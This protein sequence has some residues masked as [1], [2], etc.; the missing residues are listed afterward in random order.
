MRIII[1]NLRKH[2]VTSAESLQ[3]ETHSTLINHYY[4]ISVSQI[5]L[6]HNHDPTGSFLHL[7][8]LLKNLTKYEG[9]KAEFECEVVGL[10][11]P[12]F[13]WYK[14]ERVLV[15]SNLHQKYEFKTSPTGNILKVKKLQLEDEGQYK[16]VASNPLGTNTTH[17]YLTIKPAKNSPTKKKSPNSNND[18]INDHYEDDDE[19]DDKEEDDDYDNDDD[20]DDDVILKQSRGRKS[21]N[22]AGKKQKNNNMDGNESGSCESYRGSVCSKFIDQS[23][24]FV[25][26][27]H[28]QNML[29]EWMT[30]IKKKSQ[31]RGLCREDCESLK[32]MHC[33]SEYKLV[34]D[35]INSVNLFDYNRFE[36]L[37]KILDSANCSTLR[38]YAQQTS[39]DCYN[40]NVMMTSYLTGDKCFSD[41]G[42]TYRGVISSS[43]SG[44]PCLKWSSVG[45]F[46]EQTGVG[47]MPSLMTHNYCRNNDQSMSSPWCFVDHEGLHRIETCSVLRC[48]TNTE[49]RDGSSENENQQRGIL[50]GISCAFLLIVI[51][52]VIICAKVRK[53]KSEQKKKK[54]SDESEVL[55]QKSNSSMHMKQLSDRQS[56]QTSSTTSSAPNSIHPSNISLNYELCDGM[57]GKIYKGDLL[58]GGTAVTAVFKTLDP[59]TD[60]L[61]APEFWIKIDMMTEFHH[62]NITCVLGLNRTSLP[63]FVAFEASAYGDLNEYLKSNSR[64]LETNAVAEQK[65]LSRVSILP[66]T[67]LISVAVQVAGALE[68]LHSKKFIHSELNSHNVFVCENGLVKISLATPGR[69]LHYYKLIASA[70]PILLRWSAPEVITSQIFSEYSD[71]WM[72]GVLLWE[73][74]STGEI[75]YR[76]FSDM[77]VMEMIKSYRILTNPP[78]CLANIYSLMVQCW[79]K[80]APSR[81]SASEIHEELRQVWAE[82]NKSPSV[83]NSSGSDRSHNIN[84]NNNNSNNNSCNAT[85]YAFGCPV[86]AQPFITAVPPNNFNLSNNSYNLLINPSNSSQQTISNKKLPSSSSS[87]SQKSSPSSSTC[88][89]KTKNVNLMGGNYGQVVLESGMNIG[90]CKNQYLMGEMYSEQIV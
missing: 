51:V 40:V 66:H 72:F 61:I 25:Y 3:F 9:T 74:Y 53:R 76:N 4:L 17:A 15:G 26:D 55:Q 46:Y 32:T 58:S 77:E 44:R 90:D 18:L 52:L 62:P 78:Q 1:K 48:A 35:G 30:D 63:F 42:Q 79:H 20:D 10:P 2:L 49:I 27:I 39:A 87:A 23:L 16:C 24:I 14:N 7:E 57:Y 45:K 88:N 83:N 65:C 85:L 11:V 80:N 56:M 29:E 73:I 12:T 75:P 22:M 68:F 67:V 34:K 89:F 70:K 33:A 81:P 86:M 19:D 13:T 82:Q 50:I 5:S 59:S 54:S 36:N 28:H 31:S 6:H 37:R 43:S 60:P 8:S 69:G 64:V 71:V 41:R 21:G 38:S 47:T 84:N